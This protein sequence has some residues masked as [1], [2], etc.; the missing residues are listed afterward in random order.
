MDIDGKKVNVVRMRIID[1]C[2]GDWKVYFN[3][4]N[5]LNLFIA[6]TPETY[7]L[8]FKIHTEQHD[9]S[10]GLGVSKTYD[11]L[12]PREHLGKY[13]NETVSEPYQQVRGWI[14]KGD[15][16]VDLGE[17]KTDFIKVEEPKLPVKQNHCR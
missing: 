2:P 15:E 1:P 7:Y 5:D 4:H 3:H 16:K 6:D 13:F 11:S 14:V 8:K 17:T 9:V 10:K 12:N